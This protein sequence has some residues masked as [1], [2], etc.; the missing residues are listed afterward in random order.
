MET[1]TI[2]NGIEIAAT[3]AEGSVELT[4]AKDGKV[5]KTCDARDMERFVRPESRQQV[6]KI[7]EAV[8]SSDEATAYLAAR[9]AEIEADEAEYQERTGHYARYQYGRNPTCSDVM[10]KAM[11]VQG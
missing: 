2:I 4:F 5:V 8:K 7:I 3:F 6:A 1:K 9:K 10:R 11:A